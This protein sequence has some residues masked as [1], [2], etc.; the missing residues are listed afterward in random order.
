M[1]SQ[2]EQALYYSMMEFLKKYYSIIGT[3]LKGSL[4][5]RFTGGSKRG[6]GHG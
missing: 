2:S 5:S 6:G 4:I 3:L 1:S